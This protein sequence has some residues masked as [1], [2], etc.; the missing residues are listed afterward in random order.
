MNRRSGAFAAVE[1]SRVVA[2]TVG[3]HQVSALSACAASRISASD[4][5]CETRHTMSPRAIRGSLLVLCM[6]IM[7]EVMLSEVQLAAGLVPSDIVVVTGISFERYEI[8]KAA[9]AFRYVLKPSV[10]VNP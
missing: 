6:H 2:A 9:R 10:K 7:S 4:I 8:I 5:A 1:R 3:P